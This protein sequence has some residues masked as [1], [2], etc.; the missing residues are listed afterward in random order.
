MFCTITV[1]E[2]GILHGD[3]SSLNFSVLK[4]NRPILIFIDGN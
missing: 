2:L 1:T 4:L 3:G